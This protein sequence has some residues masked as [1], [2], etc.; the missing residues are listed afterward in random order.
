MA[1]GT[2]LAGWMILLMA[3]PGLA[4]DTAPVPTLGQEQPGLVPKVY[5][6]GL[7]SVPHRFVHGLCLSRD[8]RE[9]YFTVRTPDWSSSQIMFTHLEKGSWTQPVPLSFGRLG[10]SLAD[11]DQSLYF[12]GQGA[13]VWKARR[14]AG[15]W[16]EPEVLPAPVNSREPAWSCQVSDLG[17]LWICSW[18]TGGLGRCDVWQ[19]RSK[20]GRFTEAINPRVLNTTGFDCYPVA[21][22]N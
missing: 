19:I 3:G 13:K 10:P 21:G 5:A 18:R 14:V 17:N 22:P 15:A 2:A 16:S 20:E 12:I 7:I 1:H 9:C 8:G 6:P 11:G 4:Q